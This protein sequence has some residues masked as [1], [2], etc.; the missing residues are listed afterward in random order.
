MAMAMAMAIAR[1]RRHSDD[2]IFAVCRWLAGD[3]R[4]TNAATD[5]CSLSSIPSPLRNG[6]FL[7]RFRSRY[8]DARPPGCSRQSSSCCGDVVRFGV[9]SALWQF[10]CVQQNRNQDGVHPFLEH[11]DKHTNHTAAPAHEG[12]DSSSITSHSTA[13]DSL[14]RSA[15]T[16]S[17]C[18]R[19]TRPARRPA[20]LRSDLEH[21]AH[22][23][24][25][26]SIPR[27]PDPTP[28]V[29]WAPLSTPRALPTAWETA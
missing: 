21:G 3:S 26:H 27:L 9:R 25:M 28:C 15:S 18:W 10:R 4:E 14:C 13:V 1:W 6:A 23:A 20:N 8:H 22:V 19:Q 11:H 5:V 16:R 2:L 24:M 17:P 29:Q 7:Q 12:R